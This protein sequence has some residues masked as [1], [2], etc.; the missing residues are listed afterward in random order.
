M[1]YCIS[2]HRFRTGFIACLLVMA[3]PAM[4]QQKLLP[5]QNPRY[6]ESMQLYLINEDSL[7]AREGTTVQQTYKAYQ[8]MEAK[9][10]RKEQRRQDRRERRRAYAYGY[11]WGSSWDTWGYPAYTYGYGYPSYSFGH[12]GHHRSYSPGFQW[13]DLATVTALAMGAYLLFR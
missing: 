11:G 3:M 2:K 5:D 8:F 12:Y 4:A 7:T 1:R 13:Y 9:M 10:E 6:M